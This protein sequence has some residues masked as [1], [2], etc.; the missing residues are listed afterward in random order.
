MQSASNTAREEKKICLKTSRQSPILTK[1]CLWSLEPM[2][3]RK[4]KKC[5]FI[6][7]RW[8]K[9]FWSSSRVNSTVL[10]EFNSLG[11]YIKFTLLELVER[12]GKGDIPTS[13]K[14]KVF[15]LTYIVLRCAQNEATMRK[16]MVPLSFRLNFLFYLFIYFCTINLTEKP[17]RKNNGLFL[18]LE[19]V[20]VLFYKCLEN[21]G[22][23][24]RS[25]YF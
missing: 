12:K 1:G 19:I 25:V 6:R 8:E 5:F 9:M 23:E 16:M 24:R 15:V 17:I 7:K 21:Q 22:E 14:T 10:S 18:L 4:K 13:F 20:F 3:W 2:N 11:I